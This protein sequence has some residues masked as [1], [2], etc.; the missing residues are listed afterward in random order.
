[1]VTKYVNGVKNLVTVPVATGTVIAKYDI[2]CIESGYGIPASDIADA[3]DAAA[4][5]ELAADEFWGIAQTASDTG[6]TE[7]LVVDIGH[8][9]TYQMDLQSAS[10]LSVGD[11]LEIYATTAANSATLLV[12]GTTSQVFICVKDQ[13]SQVSHKVQMLPQLLRHGAVN[14]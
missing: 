7:D 6:E 4:N 9:S 5:R 8:D 12:A 1:M 13:A 3:G 2:V 11:L 14:A 10:A